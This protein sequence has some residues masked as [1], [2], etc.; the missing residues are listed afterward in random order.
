MSINLLVGINEEP[1]LSLNNLRSHS[2]LHQRHGHVESKVWAV[3][4][5]ID[6][7]GQRDGRRSM[8]VILFFFPILSCFATHKKYMCM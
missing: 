7:N 8:A 6:A 3:G 4:N 1:S 5:S 2:L